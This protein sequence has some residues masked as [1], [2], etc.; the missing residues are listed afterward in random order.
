[1]VVGVMFSPLTAVSAVAALVQ[2]CSTLQYLYSGGRA[3][4]SVSV[5]IQHGPAAASGSSRVR[6]LLRLRCTAPAES[7]HCLG[8][9]GRTPCLLGRARAVGGHGEPQALRRRHDFA[10]SLLTTD[11]IIDIIKIVFS[12]S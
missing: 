12:T 1:M 11:D 7:D 2:S 8:V 9:D 5:L 4:Q 10:C 3:V 6:S